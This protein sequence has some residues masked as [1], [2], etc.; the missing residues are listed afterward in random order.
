[1]ATVTPVSTSVFDPVVAAAQL[2]ETGVVVV[3][4]AFAADAHELAELARSHVARRF[5]IDEG[6]P[7]TW[8]RSCHGAI[9][10]KRFRQPARFDAVV[11]PPVRAVLDETFGPGGWR[12][13]ASNRLL[14]TPP[15]RS[16]SWSVPTGFHLD[17]PI[18]RPAWPGPGVLMFSFLA[19]T[20]PGGG[21]TCVVPGTVRLIDGF[22]AEHGDLP[23]ERRTD[24]FL[25][26]QGE[27]LRQLVNEDDRRPDRTE[28]CLAGTMIGDVP[29]RVVELTGAAGDVVITHLYTL[30]S[31]AP[32]VLP[33]LRLMLSSAIGTAS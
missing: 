27:W 23:I 10:T 16:S 9:A 29:V 5:G 30:H 21:G 14:V 28:Q 11:A 6:D 24:T 12:D 13:G 7:S 18:G 22:L 31:A 33:R 15:A 2:R 20:P 25:R 17:V 4:G 8:D 26:R 3:P 32:N 19:D 1:M